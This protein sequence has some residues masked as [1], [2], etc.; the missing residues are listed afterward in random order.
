MRFEELLERFEGGSLSHAETAAALGS[1]SVPCAAGAS[2]TRKRAQMAWSIGG[3]A[4]PRPGGRPRTSS[5]ACVRCTSST[6]RGFTIKHF[7]EKL[8]KRHGSQL[9]Y[10]TTRLFLQ[11]TGTVRPARGPARIAASD[12]AGRGA[13]CS[14]TRTPR[15]T[16]GWPSSRR[17]IW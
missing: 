11:K 1:A 10:T 17:S 3:L 16:V 9:G 5:S 14:C 6:A 15:G 4:N 8:A 7:R 13:A 12:R 2:A